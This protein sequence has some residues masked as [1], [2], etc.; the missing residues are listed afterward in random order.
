M[1]WINRLAPVAAAYDPLWRARSVRIL[2]RGGFD[3]DREIDLSLRWTAPPEGGRW[4]DVGCG[5]GFSLRAVHVRRPDL[6]L[7]GIDASPAFVRVAKRR[8][9]RTG[10]PSTFA[11]ATAERL[12]CPDASFDVVTCT[13]T[14]NELRDPS[15]ALR[16]TARVLRPGGHA[17][18]MA[19]LPADG[20][21]G[22]IAR[23]PA[24][25]AGIRFPTAEAWV[26]DAERAGLRFVRAERRAPLWL[27]AFVRP[28]A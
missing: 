24:R 26:A 28:D 15:A 21:L 12:P 16:E 5:S 22:A 4:L 17:F 23:A 25:A 10:V 11:L 14:P 6:E 13:G 2:T 9:R 27:A 19:I 3:V 7:H 20:A 8:A 18:W 1:A